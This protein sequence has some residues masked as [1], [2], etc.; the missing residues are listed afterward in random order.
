MRANYHIEGF[1][2]MKA[3]K[4]LLKQHGVEIAR[5]QFC[6]DY[7]KKKAGFLWKAHSLDEELKDFVLYAK[8]KGVKIKRIKFHG[9]IHSIWFEFIH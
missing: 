8:E 3:I 4:M 6:A 9:L 7:G 5:V 2:K 1:P